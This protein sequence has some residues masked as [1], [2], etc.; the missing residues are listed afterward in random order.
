M[1]KRGPKRQDPKTHLLAHKQIVGDC[2]EYTGYRS[3]LGY[4]KFS[5]GRDRQVFVH[6]LAYE[7]FVGPITGNL[8]V[9]H[10]CDNPPCFNPEHLFLGSQKDNL[11]DALAKG[12]CRNKVLFGE[13][14]GMAKLTRAAVKE[15]R[16]TYKPRVI[17]RPSLAHKFGVHRSVIDKVLSG[18]QWK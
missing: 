11:R 4:G 13:D 1:G 12:R 8:L 18:D 9:C 14:H 15:I 10:R 6:R 17:T 5:L 2:W 3:N 7:I 16:E